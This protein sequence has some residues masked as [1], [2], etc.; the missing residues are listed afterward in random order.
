MDE[1]VTRQRREGIFA[2]VMVL[3][4]KSTV[5]LAIM[6]IGVVLEESGFVKGGGTQPAS[7]LL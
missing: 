4:R 3:T 2:G 7:A 5:A 6:L 1:I